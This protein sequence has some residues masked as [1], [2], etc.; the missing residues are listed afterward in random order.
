MQNIIIVNFFI[1]L[2]KL[3]IV[4]KIIYNNVL[5]KKEMISYSI[6]G[7]RVK[8]A[9]EQCIKTFNRL[10]IMFPD[11]KT[12]RFCQLSDF[13]T[14]AV[15]IWKF[16]KNGLILTDKKRNISAFKLLRNFSNGIDE[17]REFQKRAKGIH[18]G[19][20]LYREY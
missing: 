12:I 7:K 13:Y 16:E 11:L 15:L 14:L 17:V 9:R 10:K 5:F 8:Y 3:L 6:S 2:L 4:M 20:E 18:P 19:Q 1:W